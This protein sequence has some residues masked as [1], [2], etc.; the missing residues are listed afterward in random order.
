MRVL[1]HQ[2]DCI[3]VN[4][5]SQPACQQTLQHLAADYPERIKLF[6]HVRNMGKGA[7]VMTGILHADE[8]GYT[9]VLQIDADGQHNTNDIPVFLK[10]AETE[11]ETM[12]SGYPIYDQSVPAIRLYCRYLTHIWVWINTLTLTIKDS[13]CGFRV[14]PVA[15]VLKLMKKHRFGRRMTFDTDII[16]RLYWEGVKIVNIPTKVT[17]PT[18]GISHFRPLTDNIQISL[19]HAR[20]F[21]GMLI[22]IPRLL[23]L[24]WKRQ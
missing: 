1:A 7:A 15:S 6:S 2:I 9:H 18:D 20:L 23:R 3:L 16:V 19:M 10:K 4:D 21:F 22:R 14:Y 12:I 11:R 24:K 5:G 17:Y 13:M 8:L